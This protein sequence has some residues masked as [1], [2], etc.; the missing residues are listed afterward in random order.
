MTDPKDL[1]PDLTD[2]RRRAEAQL[3]AEAIPPKDLTRPRPPG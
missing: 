1:P 2:L 3:E